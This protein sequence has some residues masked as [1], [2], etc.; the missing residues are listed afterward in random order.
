MNEISKESMNKTI[1]QYDREPYGTEFRANVIS[2]EQTEH[3]FAV[4]LDQ[5]LFFPEEGGQSPD[6]GVINGCKVK[7]VQI[8][9]GVITHFLE[10]WDGTKPGESVSGRINWKE[11]FSN[12]Q[13]HSGEHILSGIIHKMFGYDNVGFHL[14]P[15]TVTMDMNGAISPE[16]L[17]IIEDTANQAV[18]DNVNVTA[19][20]RNQEEIKDLKYRS[21]IEIEGPVRIVTIPGYDI[22]ACCAPHVRSTGE[23]GLIKILRAEN[24]KGGTRLT[25]A[26]GS[27][28][29]QEV[30][31]RQNQM[32]EI[33]QY[34][35]SKP[36]C[37]MDEIKRL[38][39]DIVSL[40]STINELKTEQ[41]VQKAKE[42][43]TGNQNLCIFEESMD[44]GVQKTFV[45]LVLEKCDETCAVFIGDDTT[46]YR[47]IIGSKKDARVVNQALKDKFQAKG[48]GRPDMVQGSLSASKE[49]I[50][51]VLNELWNGEN[52]E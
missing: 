34:L 25:I 37:V 42:I 2:V 10:N 33:S 35:S 52:H 23:I 27:R 13:N 12:M 41:I 22:C 4:I 46:G 49:M 38:Q 31:T 17:V 44:A 11:R 39:D 18:Y 48:G 30:R 24:Y 32:M 7:D 47:Y 1:K 36:E 29:L 21:K 26:C 51:T 28:A 19:E 16:Q 3:G 14:S 20:Y 50:N 40:K 9:K 5:T 6:T 8:K 45:N 15:Q 43:P